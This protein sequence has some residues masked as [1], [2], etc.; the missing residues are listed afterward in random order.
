MDAP[1]LADQFLQ[2]HPTWPDDSLSR[3]N[4]TIGSGSS[5]GDRELG[6]FQIMRGHPAIKVP[7]FLAGYWVESSDRVSGNT[8]F[9]HLFDFLRKPWR[10]MNHE[11]IQNS[12]APFSGF[13]SALS[14]VMEEEPTTEVDRVL[15]ARPIP[16]ETSSLFGSSPPEHD[17]PHKRSRPD[18]SSGS[19]V[20]SDPASDQSISDRRIKSEV[21]TNSCINELLRCV[22]ELARKESDPV[23]RMEWSIVPDTFKVC[24]GNHQFSSTNDGGLVQRA[25]KSGVWQRASTICYCS[26]EVV[27]TQPSSFIVD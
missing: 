7:L 10:A 11:Q 22:T 14:Q 26:V 17:Y 8:N 19:Y 24:A 13:I 1:S 4:D 9:Q 16:D 25:I 18:R 21:A 23:S 5:W 15:R 12:V 3:R 20:P 2:S 27:I 6:T